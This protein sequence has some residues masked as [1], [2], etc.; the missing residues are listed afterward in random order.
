MIA[1]LS[2]LLTLFSLTLLTRVIL[3]FVPGKSGALASLD[4]L[5]FSLT[6]PV[7]APVRRVL[8]PAGGFDW[9]ILVVLLAI[10]V[11]RALLFRGLTGSDECAALP[12]CMGCVKTG[13]RTV[14]SALGPSSG[15]V[16]RVIT[17]S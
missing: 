10:W 4:E 14:E 5:V 2:L 16:Q 13:T 11:L 6:E 8:P 9:S 17:N 12:L 3:S 7:L 15:S 1:V